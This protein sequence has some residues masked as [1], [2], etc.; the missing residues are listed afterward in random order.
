MLRFAAYSFA[1]L[2]SLNVN[3]NQEAWKKGLQQGYKVKGPYFISITIALN[4]HHLTNWPVVL[5]FSPSL[6]QCCVSWVLE[7]SFVALKSYTERKEV[8]TKIWGHNWE[9][10]RALRPPTNQLLPGYQ[11]GALKSPFSHPL[12]RLS[13]VSHVLDGRRRV[14]RTET[15]GINLVPKAFPLENGRDREK[16]LGT[17]LP[18]N[19]MVSHSFIDIIFCFAFLVPL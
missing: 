1:V 14:G 10:N 8:E 17:R 16:A 18:G 12:D 7:A 19:L 9:S 6:H 13:P 4:S 3:Y 5:P 15:L 2:F 11:H